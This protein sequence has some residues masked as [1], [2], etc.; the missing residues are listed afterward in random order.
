[1]RPEI[2]LIHAQWSLD[3]VSTETNKVP[4]HQSGI[5]GISFVLLTHDS[6]DMLP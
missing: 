3:L 5:P 1:M 2:S 6:W 4:R